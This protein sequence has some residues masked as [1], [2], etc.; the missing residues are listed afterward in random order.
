M[1]KRSKVPGLS[2]LMSLTSPSYRANDF[3]ICKSDSLADQ[4]WDQLESSFGRQ[5]I[6]QTE[7]GTLWKPKR[8]NPI[9]K[10]LEILSGTPII[11]PLPGPWDA[12]QSEEVCP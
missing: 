8:I 11:L 7:D 10:L 4:L 6:I 5:N 12:T 1:L 3:T 2:D 9:F